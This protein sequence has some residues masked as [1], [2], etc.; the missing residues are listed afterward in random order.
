MNNPQ[1]SSLFRSEVLEARTS[2]HLGTV[3][4]AQPLSTALIVGISAAI[5][6]VMIL[7]AFHG[8]FTKKARVSG[9]TIPRGGS[10]SISSPAIGRVQ[11]IFIREGVKVSAGDKLAEISSEHEGRDGDITALVAKQLMARKS[12]L[13]YELSL[14]A[15]QYTEREEIL[16][17]QIANLEQQLMRME[18]ER[19]IISRRLD[20]AHK[21]AEGYAKL[22]AEG[23]VR[24][25]QA[26]QKQEELLDL[27]ARVSSLERA[28]IELTSALNTARQQKK[29][30]RTDLKS[31]QL[32]TNRAISSINQEI[33]EN[34]NRRATYIRASQPGVVST[35]SVQVGQSITTAQPLMTILP[36]SSICAATGNEE[37]NKT[38]TAC[39]DK[40]DST[41]EAHLFAPSRT[42]GF[43]TQGQE[44]LIRFDAFPYQK[45]GLQ[46]G[47]V[48]EVSSAPFSAAELPNTLSSS[49]LPRAR[50][51]G[52]AEGEGLYRI[53]VRLDRQF[54]SLYGKDQQLKPGLVLEADVSLDRRQI[55]EW[56]LEPVIAMRNRQ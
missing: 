24:G 1:S 47:E 42:A 46:R 37:N 35:I 55:W 33:A 5:T 2:R 32:Q 13:E 20:L 43:V 22:Q 41:L 10:I 16:T 51:T 17:V 29:S 26:Q 36:E 31:D 4:L 7:F 45:F 48:V 39:D 34:E 40:S 8:D 27:E 50:A 52:G 30:L 19:N 44:V 28:K 15:E 12:T 38:F 23:F 6:I 54:I 14:R 9:I 49:L 53:K 11:R 25:L 21:A 56:V 18:G 3:R